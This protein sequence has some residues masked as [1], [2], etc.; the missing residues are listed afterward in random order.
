MPSAFI[1]EI[2]NHGLVQR[3]FFTSAAA[4]FFASFGSSRSA[5]LN[6]SQRGFFASAASYFFSSSAIARHF[7]DRIGVLVERRDVHEVQQQVGALQ[8]AQE[9]V[10]RGPA[11]SAAP[12]IRPGMSATTNERL[13]STRT[14]PRFGCSVVKG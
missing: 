2:T 10:A 9:L 12:S 3:S 13:V 5:L 8:V 11:P 7:R 6:T 14:T 1:A 4:R